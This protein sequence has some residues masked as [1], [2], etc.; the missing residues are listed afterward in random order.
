MPSLVRD[1]VTGLVLLAI[2]LVWSVLVYKTIPPGQG[3]GDVG[4]RAFPLLLGLI[5]AGLSAAMVF[6]SLWRKSHAPD[7]GRIEI[8]PALE[9][10]LEFSIVAS[11]VVSIIAYGYLMQKIGFLLA[12]PILVTTLMM[13]VLKSRNWITIASMAAGLTLGCWLIFGKLLGAY[14]PRGTWI[15]L[16]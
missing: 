14:L 15:S 16:G 11:V 7:G 2:A 6:A 5:L 12:T 1:R 3:D 10:R 4:A 13:A 8:K 9:R